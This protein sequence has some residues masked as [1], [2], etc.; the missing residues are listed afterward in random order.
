[1]IENMKRTILFNVMMVLALMINAQDEYFIKNYGKTDDLKVR[2]CTCITQINGFIWV[3]TSM[4][5]YAFDGNHTHPYTVPDEEGLGGYYGRVLSLEASA[6]K[7]LWVGTRK[8]IYVFEMISESMHRFEAKGM[9]EHPDVRFIKFDQDGFLWAIMSGKAYR[10]DVKNKVAECIGDG[11]MS[12]S[13]MTIT[14][15]GTVWFGDNSAMLYRYD[16]VTRRLHSYDG[17]PAGVEM[18]TFL[19]SITEMRNGQLALVTYRNGVFLFSPKDKTS[20]IL[21]TC[22]DEG[23][24]IIGHTSLTPDGDELWVGT[25]RGVVI[26]RM[27][28]GRISG[29]RQSH[30]SVNSLSDNAVHTLFLDDEDGVWA[31]TFFGGM[32]RISLASHNFSVLTPENNNKDNIDVFRELCEDNAGHLWVGSED[33]GLYLVDRE[34]GVLHKANIN[35]KGEEEPFNIQTMM[36]VGDNLWLSSITRGIYVV[37]TRTMNLV[38]R[39]RKTNKTN[40]GHMI[41]GISMCQQDGTIFVSSTSGV[42]IFDPKE[43]AFIMIPEMTNTYAHHLF[44]DKEGNVWVTTFDKGLWKIQKKKGQWKAER[45]P[46]T[47]PCTT[48]IMQDSQGT[49]WVGTD[50]HGLVSYDDKTGETRQ[51]NDSEGLKHETVTN[52]LEDMHHRLWI[53]TFNG[54]YSYNLNKKVV[55]HMTVANGL[56]SSYLNYSSGYLDK[57]AYIYLGSYKG[58]VCF[59]PTSFVLSKERLRPYFLNL[60]VNGQYVT[61]NDG[62]GILEQTL[63]QTKEL[64]LTRDQNTFTIMYAAPSYRSGEIVWYRYRLNPDEPW[65]VTDNAQPIQ[66]SN[67]STGTYRITLQASYNPERWEGEAAV[68]VVNVATPVALS[69]WAFIAYALVIIAIVVV[70]MWLIKKKEIRKLKED[71]DKDV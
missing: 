26:Y 27:R 64:N 7:N 56:P 33:G 39:F 28:D 36:M 22:D 60:Y 18:V 52:I 49:Y 25:E 1:M 3:G 59:T 13:C 65:T 19:A 57:N 16:S 68:L 41:G 55:N 48:V 34:K 51:Q 35:W 11:V 37:D 58:L 70:V 17:R 44:V 23:T 8:G 4:G 40:E 20:K 29:I 21:M 46:F 30:T 38:Q 10:I 67:L 14:K 66:L 9:P 45:T 62:S 42:Y 47:Y 63:F 12:P 2:G 32:N 15:D 43:E 50:L 71:G 69:V 61:P 6:D 31:G 53:S 24:P 54:L 5:F